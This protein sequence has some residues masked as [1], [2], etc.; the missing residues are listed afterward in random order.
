MVYVKIWCDTTTKKIPVG[1]RATFR[2]D[3]EHEDDLCDKVSFQ[4]ET[5]GMRKVLENVQLQDP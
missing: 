1:Q 2:W 4:C 3:K 5:T